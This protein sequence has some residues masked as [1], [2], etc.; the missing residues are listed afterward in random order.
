MPDLQRP[1]QGREFGEP[2]MDDSDRDYVDAPAADM[3]VHCRGCDGDG[4]R[5][6]PRAAMIGSQMAAVAKPEPC[7]ECAVGEDQRPTGRVNLGTGPGAQLRRVDRV[8]LPG[9]DWPRLRP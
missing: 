3:V 9:D 2:L 6:V 5:Y 8:T 1:R 4:W 7:T